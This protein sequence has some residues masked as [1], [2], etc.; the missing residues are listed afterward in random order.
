M[1]LGNEI[2][3]DHVSN[4]LT[5]LFNCSKNESHT[6]RQSF[7]LLSRRLRNNFRVLSNNGVL[8]LATLKEGAA[9]VFGCPREKFTA[10][11]VESVR[12]FI[13]QGGAVLILSKEGVAASQKANINDIIQEFGITVNSDV[14]VQSIQD[15]YFHP[16][17]VLLKG[18]GVLCKELK[19]NLGAEEL[20]MV[21]PYGATLVVE[22]PAKAVLYSGFFSYPISCPLGAFWQE[23]NG[24]GRVAVLGSVSIF[25]DA[26]LDKEENAKFCDLLFLWL[27]G[28]KDIEFEKANEEEE[29]DVRH[30]EHVSNTETLANRLRCCLQEAEE[31][32][33]DFT[34]LIDDTPFTYH[35]NLI[36]EVRKLYGHLGVKHAPLT[37]ITPQFEMPIP[38]LQPAVFPPVLRELSAP[39]VDLFD[40]DDCFA[41]PTIRL[42]QLTNKTQTTWFY[43]FQKPLLFLT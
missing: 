13:S 3:K 37:L 17:E 30:S 16:K 11:E 34:Q 28:K 7:K 10:A 8:S 40:L 20:Q 35:T 1:E 25:E 12:A 5:L 38:P 29:L 14:L 2:D 23:A 19:I 4:Y 41:S 21:Y 43:T 15:K 42:A 27:A 22:Q 18:E 31:L 6:P 9:V 24:K 32:P 26:W 33:R 36:P 39:A